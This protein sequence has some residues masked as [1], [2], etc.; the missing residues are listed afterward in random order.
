ME[1]P[2]R[3]V[4]PRNAWLIDSMLSDVI[5]RGTG[6]RARSLERSD[7]AGKTGTTNDGRDT[8]FAGYNGNL[9]AATWVGFDQER[10][11]G[12]GEAGGA[13]ALPLWIDFMGPALAGSEPS[14][15]PQPPGLVTVRISAETGELARAGDPGAIFET[16]R[17]GNAPE[18]P[19]PGEARFPTG[20]E[21]DE[22]PLF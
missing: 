7:L 13:T 4:E 22:E 16:F 8:W 9:V 10:P 3:A 5:R 15:I 17:V 21:Q 14:R 6:V 19:A 2:P 12:R 20:R 18:A 11:L 1:P